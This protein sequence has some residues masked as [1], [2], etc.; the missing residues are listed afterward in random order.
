MPV[1]VSLD[2]N[3]SSNHPAL[4][5]M[6]PDSVKLITLRTLH[7]LT[8]EQVRDRTG[9]SSSTLV[10]LE[11]GSQ[12]NPRLSTLNALAKLYDC[13]TTELLCLTMEEL[14]NQTLSKGH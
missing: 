11:N 13:K 10:N 2:Y 3:T 12:T 6:I 7:K 5:P 8:L 4:A 1:Q 9:L 14:Q